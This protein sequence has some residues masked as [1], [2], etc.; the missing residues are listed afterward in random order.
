MRPH[1]AVLDGLR[2]TAA[3]SVVVFHF[4][5]LSLAHVRPDSLWLR[6]AHLAVDFFFCLSGYVIAYAYDDRRER[7]STADFLRARLIRLH[8]M[9]VF[10]LLL[11]LASFV[12]DPFNAAAAVHPWLHAQ[13]APFWKLAADTT[14]GFLMLPAWPLPNRFGAYF[15]L[16]APSWSLM[17]EYVASVVF[18][19]LLWRQ[20]RSWLLPTVIVAA[21]G[22]VLVAY[23]VGHLSVGFAWEQMPAAFTRTAFSFCFGVLLFRYRVAI[24][25]RVGWVV[26]SLAMVALFIAPV[27]ERLN[28]LY[29]SWVVLLLFPLIVACGAGAPS[30]RITQPLCSFLGRISYPVYMIHYAFVMIFANL[31]AARGTDNDFLPWLIAI[32]TG[33]IVLFSYAV[34]VLYDEPARRWLQQR[35]RVR[36]PGHSGEMS[37]QQE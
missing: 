3:I 32:L 37:M 31:R 22:V 30:N 25:A 1:L 34:L 29:E 10:G 4:Q 26:L 9:V 17:W 8:P 16:N 12:F 19:L 24:R 5:E 35:V 36:T 7:M 23:T 21:I 14:A 27:P 28:W 2:G 20:R 18:G 6:H 11:G 33:L 15:P 13:T